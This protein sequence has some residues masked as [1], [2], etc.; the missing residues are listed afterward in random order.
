[1]QLTGT[2]DLRVRRTVTN[3][4]RAFESLICEKEYDAI[5]VKELADRAMINK[6]TF[7]QYYSNLDEILAELKST[8][9]S[10]YL[11]LIAY[12]RIP[13]DMDKIN[14]AFFTFSAAAGEVYD[15][16]TCS[17]DYG[18]IQEE[19]MDRTMH[20]HWYSSP[21][22]Q[23]FDKY[24]QRIILQYIQVSTVGIYR[25]WVKDGKKMPLEELIQLSTSLICQGMN[26]LKTKDF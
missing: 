26:Y 16:I 10:S 20:D 4:R 23:S 12:Y 18:L 24:T 17:G 3:I 25:Q 6:K 11:R 9:S 2:E 7:Y 13:E 14:H 15:R 21:W 8:F 5:T 19:P 22:F 1:M